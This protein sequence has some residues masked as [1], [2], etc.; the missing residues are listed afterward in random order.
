MLYDLRLLPQ[1]LTLPLSVTSRRSMPLC[2]MLA[3]WRPPCPC[4][5]AYALDIPEIIHCRWR[6]SIIKR[7]IEDRLGSH[8]EIGRV[9]FARLSFG[10]QAPVARGALR[11]VDC[12]CTLDWRLCVCRQ[13]RLLGLPA[14]A[15]P[16]AVA[17]AAAVPVAAVPGHV[18]MPPPSVRAA[19]ADARP[20]PVFPRCFLLQPSPC[21]VGG[22]GGATAGGRH[23][24]DG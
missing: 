1:V 6:C 17:A 15:V 7:E 23:P 24:A 14:A 12:R 4:L 2:Q 19:A 5:L 21:G 18:P 13:M 22:Q 3:H 20:L 11:S 10:R 8:G 9:T 16:S